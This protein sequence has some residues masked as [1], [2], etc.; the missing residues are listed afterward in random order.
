MDAQPLMRA[1]TVQDVFQCEQNPPVAAPPLHISRCRSDQLLV[2]PSVRL[3]AVCWSSVQTALASCLPSATWLARKRPGWNW[4]EVASKHIKDW[5]LRTGCSRSD[6]RFPPISGVPERPSHFYFF[7]YFLPI[8]PA[9]RHTK[10]FAMIR[11]NKDDRW[12]LAGGAANKVWSWY[13]WC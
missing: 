12:A 3:S 5:C 11:H 6:D 8:F 13:F 9:R 2:A 4:F 7:L 1:R 10:N